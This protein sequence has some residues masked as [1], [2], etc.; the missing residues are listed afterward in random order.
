MG[1]RLKDRVLLFF[2]NRLNFSY[3]SLK[4]IFYFLMIF[5]CLNFASQKIDFTNYLDQYLYQFV[6][7]IFKDSKPNKAPEVIYVNISEEQYLDTSISWNK[8]TQKISSYDSRLIMFTMPMHKHAII[9][10]EELKQKMLFSVDE[11]NV[12]QQD[13]AK[14]YESEKLSWGLLKKEIGPSGFLN[15][16]Q[17]KYI[18]KNGPELPAIESLLFQKLDLKVQKRFKVNFMNYKV[19]LSGMNFQEFQNSL[20]IK[21]LYKDKIVIFGL[22]KDDNLKNIPIIENFQYSKI[23]TLKYLALLTDSISQSNYVL[24]SQKL[25]ILTLFMI[26]ILF[27][28]FAPSFNLFSAAKFTLFQIIIVSSL[29]VCLLGFFNVWINLA[30]VLLFYS[31]LTI[32][33]L[34][35]TFKKSNKSISSLVAKT[36]IFLSETPYYDDMRISKDY[37]QA[38]CE[39][40][41]SLTGSEYVFLTENNYKLVY[42][43]EDPDLGKILKTISG[44]E[45]QLLNKICK[46]HGKSVL[47]KKIIFNRSP[48]GYIC[49]VGINNHN[50]NSYLDSLVSSISENLYNFTLSR[51]YQYKSK[52]SKVQNNFQLLNKMFFKISKFEASTKRKN[53]FYSET[54]LP[55]KISDILRTKLKSIGIEPKSFDIVSLLK[56]CAD[57][58]QEKIYT[59]MNECIKKQKEEVINLKFEEKELGKI[60]LGVVWTPSLDEKFY[61]NKQMLSGFY[62]EFEFFS[63]QLNYKPIK[64]T[65]KVN[66]NGV[67]LIE[68]STYTLLE[69]FLEKYRDVMKKASLPITIQS[70]SYDMI[71]SELYNEV[72]NIISN[73]AVFLSKENISSIVFEERKIVISGDFLFSEIELPDV[74][75][76]IFANSPKIRSNGIVEVFFNKYSTNDEIV[77]LVNQELFTSTRIIK[78]A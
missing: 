19:R 13:V 12:F 27:F 62:L 76:K 59:L 40:L 51:S 69:V 2:K 23:S 64:I 77:I 1:V 3:I 74:S 17:D 55:V 6:S 30:I 5:L 29:V 78:A 46:I 7:S 66:Q 58:D 14:Y 37:W 31:C 16:R 72:S 34:F 71:T 47:L 21:N 20:S 56:V 18:S 57:L 75:K 65:D 53:I 9:W 43:P 68:K 61:S 28:C 67:G 45:K 36:G 73:L 38:F 70:Y 32:C 33:Y 63:D 44:M 4:F 8:I 11:K 52:L 50:E 26:F 25:L 60:N 22:Y 48:V 35:Y 10:N 39:Q 15:D 49:M 54:G 41:A 24:S 42:E